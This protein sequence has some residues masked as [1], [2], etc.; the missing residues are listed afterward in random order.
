MD[1]DRASC[2]FVSACVD[3]FCSECSLTDA[4]WNVTNCDGDVCVAANN[5]AVELLGLG[6]SACSGRLF[7]FRVFWKGDDN[8][9]VDYPPSAVFT[10]K[11]VTSWTTIWKDAG[12]W[13]SSDNPT[14]EFFVRAVGMGNV[15]SSNKLLVCENDD[16]CDGISNLEDECPNT[17]YGEA[18]ETEGLLMGCSGSQAECI[19]KVDC[20]MVTW[21][22]C[23]DQNQKTRN[24]CK[25]KDTGLDYF[26]AT[27]ACCDNQDT[28]RCNLG[29]CENHGNWIPTVRDCLLEADF[30]FFTPL[31]VLLVI[32]LLAVFYMFR[33]KRR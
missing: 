12:G 5:S 18:V 21:S 11:V 32:G 9:V 25:N 8:D 16:D 30:P 19:S 22:E 2:E 26:D 10:D 17:P 27:G 31:N 1:G 15:Y 3:G 13:F 33:T 14:Y 4:L 28:C 7:K 24:I 29:T 20:S 23:N 6:S